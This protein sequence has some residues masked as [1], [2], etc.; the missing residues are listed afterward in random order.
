MH[1]YTCRRH[2]ILSVGEVAAWAATISLVTLTDMI[3]RFLQTHYDRRDVLAGLSLILGFHAHKDNEGGGTRFDVE[4][5]ELAAVVQG[6]Q[7]QH[8][9]FHT[10]T[11]VP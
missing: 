9:P 8:A 6:V 10:D 3:S 4:N 1:L 11:C 5:N 2:V 7:H